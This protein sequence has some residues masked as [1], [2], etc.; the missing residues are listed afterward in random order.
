LENLQS[1][2][3]IKSC[4]SE[5]VEIY[6]GS[7]AKKVRELFQKARAEKP[8]IIFIDE[9]EAIGLQRSPNTSTYTNNVERYSTLNQLLAEMDGLN[10]MEDIIV[11]AATNREDLLDAALV[12]SGRFDMKILINIPDI[13]TRYRIYVHYLEKY[14]YDKDGIDNEVLNYLANASENFSGAN[15]EQIVNEAARVSFAKKLKLID[16]DDLINSYEKNKETIKKFR[17]FEFNHR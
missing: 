7:G 5:F 8:A 11:I 17:E 9:L 1:I 6:V 4:A 10:D 2:S 16:K 12:R 3:F 13:E 14:G 15:I